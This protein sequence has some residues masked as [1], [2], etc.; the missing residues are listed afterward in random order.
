MISAYA[1]AIDAWGQHCVRL[2]E[3]PK[4]QGE[5]VKNEQRS[6]TDPDWISTGWISADGTS[7]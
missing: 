3:R 5:E 2:G 4:R 7:E 6:L 1:W